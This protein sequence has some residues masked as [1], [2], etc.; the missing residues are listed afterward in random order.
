M[1]TWYWT[2]TSTSE[3]GFT[4]TKTL[5]ATI[6]VTTGGTAT[7]LGAYI[8]SYDPNKHMKLALYDTSNNLHAYTGP[9]DI[10]ND[11]HPVEKKGS[12]ISPESGYTVT[13]STTYKIVIMT[14]ETFGMTIFQEGTRNGEYYSTAQDYETFPMDP[15]APN[16]SD[17]PHAR[18]GI[19][20]ESAASPVDITVSES[21]SVSELQ[22]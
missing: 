10:S 16:N 12:I 19:Y 18:V 7:Q 4:S 22:P 2:N 3:E 8:K 21:L 11:S 9:I 5:G 20:V 1:G 17:A 13:D 15:Y 14:D 6:T